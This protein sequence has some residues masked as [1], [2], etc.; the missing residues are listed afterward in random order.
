LQLSDRT[1]PWEFSIDSRFVATSK[2]S[3]L[4]GSGWR[5]SSSAARVC[6]TVCCLTIAV[7]PSEGPG[8]TPPL[9]TPPSTL[10]GAAAAA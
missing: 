9:R 10:L 1:Q 4:D 5:K 7:A 8:R 2:T 3:G 6:G